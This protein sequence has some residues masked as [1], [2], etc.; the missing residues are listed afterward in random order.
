[1][2]KNVAQPTAEKVIDT[3]MER[4]QEL[5][6]DKLDVNP[7]LNAKAQAAEIGI[8]YQTFNKYL[9]GANGCTGERLFKICQY[10]NVSADYFLGLTDIKT[11]KGGMVRACKYTGLT[12]KAIVALRRQQ[13]SVMFYPNIEENINAKLKKLASIDKDISADGEDVQ[14]DKAV[15]QSFLELDDAAWAD[16]IQTLDA[17]DALDTSVFYKKEHCPLPIEVSRFFESSVFWHTLLPAV[18]S[19]NAFHN[20]ENR[21]ALVGSLE[22]SCSERNEYLLYKCQV[23]FREFLLATFPYLREDDDK[24]ISAFLEQG[25]PLDDIIFKGMEDING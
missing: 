23:A 11:P 14:M 15:F 4:L 9:S 16:L 22:M 24:Q 12:E 5:V 17:E 13:H 3:F 7:A 10:Y 20:Y 18:K 6:D 8:P 21:S 25:L 1:M 19:L 2:K